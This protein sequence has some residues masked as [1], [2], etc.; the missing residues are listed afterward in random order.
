MR[1]VRFRNKK[2]AGRVLERVHD[3]CCSKA[4]PCVG[5]CA[6]FLFFHL[7]SLSIGVDRNIDTIWM[8]SH[9]KSVMFV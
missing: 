4:M 5:M 7:N 6:H 9:A 8:L 2:S 1:A 3:F